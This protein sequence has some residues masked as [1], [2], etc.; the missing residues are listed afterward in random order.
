M[1]DLTALMPEYPF[2]YVYLAKLRLHPSSDHTVSRWIT[3]LFLD[4][5]GAPI[6]T[7]IA[8]EKPDP[9][10]LS[11]ELDCPVYFDEGESE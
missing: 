8:D 2:V 4:G 6:V 9:Q 11:N 1:P 5:D 7:D 10:K 3:E